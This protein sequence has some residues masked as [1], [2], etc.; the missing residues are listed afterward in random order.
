MKKRDEESQSEPLGPATGRRTVTCFANTLAAIFQEI[1]THHLLAGISTG[2][3]SP[4]RRQKLVLGAEKR[5]L[6]L[7]LFLFF[8]F[9]NG[10]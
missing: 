1:K 7:F 9:F 2:T 6:D 3:L 5:I 4:P 8:I 10:G